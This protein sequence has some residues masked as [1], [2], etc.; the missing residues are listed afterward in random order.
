MIAYT[1]QE[2]DEGNS[3]PD[4]DLQLCHLFLQPR[5]ELLTKLGILCL[6]AWCTD[7][8]PWNEIL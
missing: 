7:A 8:C 2:R 5:P 1:S 3:K 6:G 4:C